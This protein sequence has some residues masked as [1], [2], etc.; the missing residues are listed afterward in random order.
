MLNHRFLKNPYAPIKSK[1]K[2]IPDNKI[3]DVCKKV[4][5]IAY[6]NR[7]AEKCE[8]ALLKV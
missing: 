5:L 6:P 7:D 3:M 2:G 4:E 1:R 8:Q